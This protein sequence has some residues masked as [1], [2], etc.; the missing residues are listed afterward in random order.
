MGRTLMSAWIET[1]ST[2]KPRREP[3]S[4]T[5]MSAWIETVILDVIIKAQEVALS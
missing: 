5:L 3:R 1:D 4:R 2:V